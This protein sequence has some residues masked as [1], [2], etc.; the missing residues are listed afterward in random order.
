MQIVVLTDGSG[1]SLEMVRGRPLVDWQLDHFAACGA[2]S[3]VFCVGQDG[4]AIESHVRRALERGLVVSYAYDGGQRWGSGGVLRRAFARLE[5]E[6]VV[7]E[8]ARYLA[9]DYA[10]PL[11]ELRA[12]PEASGT[13]CVCAGPGNVLVD[14]DSVAGYAAAAPYQSYG[15]LALR[16]ATL[17]GIEDGAIWGLEALLGRLARQQKLRALLAA[18]RGYA[19]GTPELEQHLASLPPV[20]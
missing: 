10:A 4:E 7:T 9:F 18:E 6:F 14:G 5:A 13:L 19:A 1:V 2:R 20:V 15:A 8:A 11:R 16:S 12:H 3:V 17:A